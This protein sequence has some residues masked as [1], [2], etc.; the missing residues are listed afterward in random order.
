MAKTIPAGVPMPGDLAPDFT[1]TNDQGEAV[2]L[3]ALRGQ[4]VILYFYPRAD[5]PGC[6]KQACAF[7]D[8]S[9]ELAELDAVVLGLSPDPVKDLVKFR[10]KQ[11]L[12]FPLLSD[13]DHAVAEAY[14]VW[15]EK[16]MY[17]RTYMGIQ[18][19]QFVIDADG[20]IIATDYKIAPAKSVPAAMAALGA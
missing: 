17:G 2:S 7:R 9:A 19:S 3:S 14:G 5:T 12:N 10:D 4:R 18:R 6:T 1:L 15:R 8:A 20:T 13:E 11:G 16:S